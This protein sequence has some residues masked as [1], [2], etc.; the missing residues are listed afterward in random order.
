[1][2]NTAFIN[3]ISVPDIGPGSALLLWS[4]RATFHGTSRPGCM[5]C[6]FL[7]LL[8]AKRGPEL[9]R[10]L[11]AFSRQVVKLTREPIAISKPSCRQMTEDEAAL[12]WIFSAAQ[13]G[14]KGESQGHFFS[15]FNRKPTTNEADAIDKVCWSFLM[16]GSVLRPPISANTSPLLQ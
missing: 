9:L 12:V 5:A 11:V 3:S 15:L 13:A 6:A 10:D 8:G 2:K 7:K 1:M 4:I 14:E 16:R